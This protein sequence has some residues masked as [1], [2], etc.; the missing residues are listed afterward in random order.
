MAS[1]SDKVYEQMTNEE[2]EEKIRVRVYNTQ[3]NCTSTILTRF[4]LR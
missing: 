4:M 3:R 2:I 1:G